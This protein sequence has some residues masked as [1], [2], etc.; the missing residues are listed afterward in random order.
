MN[1][2]CIVSQSIAKHCNIE[3]SYCEC[4]ATMT[5]NTLETELSCDNKCGVIIDLIG[6]E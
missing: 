1:D 4:G 6:D 2:F 5:L 3:E